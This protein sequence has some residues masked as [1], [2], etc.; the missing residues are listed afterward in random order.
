M[1]G[2]GAEVGGWAERSTTVEAVFDWMYDDGVIP[3]G[4]DANG[5]GSSGCYALGD[6]ICWGHRQGI[7]ENWADASFGGPGTYT[8]TF[9][10]ACV[11]V[12]ER[13]DFSPLSCTWE[14][15]LS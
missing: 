12:V 10:A 13:G 11:P 1:T 9:G 14:G 15:Y 3:A 7:L 6:A 5:D 4:S 2:P 8:L